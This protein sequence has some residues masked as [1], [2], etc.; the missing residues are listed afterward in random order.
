[1]NAPH[2]PEANEFIVKP[3]G[4]IRSPLAARTDAPRQG[5]EGTVEGELV[6]DEA[7]HEALLGLSPGQRIVILYWMHQAARDVLQVHPRHDY[8]KPLRGVFATR[9]PARPNPIA[10][11]TVE[12]LAIDGNVIKVRGLDA[13]DHTP[14]LDIKTEVRR[15]MAEDG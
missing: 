1:M 4:F 12:I 6:I 3:I 7:Y 9:S 2:Q 14:L 11:D 5:S 10:L 13:I 15:R 8:S